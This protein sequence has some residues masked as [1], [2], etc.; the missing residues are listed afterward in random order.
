MKHQPASETEITAERIERAL[1]KLAHFMVRL[2]AEGPRLL[3]IYE[4]LEAELASRQ[5]LDNKMAE[6]RERARRIRKNRDTMTTLAQIKRGV[7]RLALNRAELALA[8]GVSTNTV[9]LMVQEGYLPKPRK[10]HSRKIWI[11]TEI[12]AAMSEWPEDGVPSVKDENDWRAE[13]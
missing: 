2:G 6:V 5:D 11:V 10:W 3:P 9:D 1:D 4:R 13:V 7:P 12:E 8:I